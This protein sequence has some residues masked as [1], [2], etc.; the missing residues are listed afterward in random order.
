[1]LNKYKAVKSEIKTAVAGT[2][3]ATGITGTRWTGVNV[4]A[5]GAAGDAVADNLLVYG[6]YEQVDYQKT[7]TAIG[8]VIS[9]DLT[10]ANLANEDH[11]LKYELSAFEFPEG[12][13]Y[14]GVI[15][16][17]VEYKDV[18][19]KLV[20]TNLQ[21]LVLSIQND[22]TLNIKIPAALANTLGQPILN[23]IIYYR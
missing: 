6:T 11:Y 3:L 23:L 7:N 15:P 17:G 18:Q 19:G 20:N 10:G 9:I 1:M 22:N 14:I 5:T 8:K 12:V 16:I 4:D 2:A 13:D 21:T